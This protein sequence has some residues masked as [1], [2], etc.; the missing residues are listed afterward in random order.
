MAPYTT[1]NQK[2]QNLQQ[3]PWIISDILNEMKIRDELHKKY[4]FE[5]NN[6]SKIIFFSDYK[7]KRNSV[8]SVIKKG[9]DEYFKKFSI[10][11]KMILKKHGKE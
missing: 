7:K 3:R 2:E 9:R 1:L 5:K 4:L 11:I 8:L 6:N 10:L